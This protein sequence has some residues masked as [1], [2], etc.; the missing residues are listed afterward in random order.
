MLVFV[1]AC[2]GEQQCPS[3][4]DKDY[5]ESDYPDCSFTEPYDPLQACEGLKVPK[6]AYGDV[7]GCEVNIAEETDIRWACWDSVESQRLTLSTHWP[8]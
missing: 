2:N 1:L 3:L 4:G 7:A 6:C 5:N 8:F